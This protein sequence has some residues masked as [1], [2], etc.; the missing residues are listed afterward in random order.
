MDAWSRARVVSV[1]AHGQHTPWDED[2]PLTGINL[3]L[4]PGEVLTPDHV[5]EW[6][7][8]MERVE[9]WVCQS[10]IDLPLDP[11]LPVHN[12]GAGFDYSLLAAG[13][14]TTIATLWSVEQLASAFICLQFRL[15]CTTGDDAAVA[16]AAAQR[17]WRDEA[18]T[19]LRARLD[20]G[21]S[22]GEA[23]VGLWAALLG[24]S[25]PE[26]AASVI[27]AHL[28]ARGA[29]AL[30][31]HTLDPPLAHAAFRF[32]GVPDRAVEAVWD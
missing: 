20:A 21:A 22:A 7:Q 6:S 25:P 29:A 3:L 26:P 5:V 28:D 1:L 15:R 23:V 17:W 30:V 18:R 24:R 12:E 27:R 8:G 32:S 2:E 19:D 4:G 13:A 14:R 11:L 31:E 9:F 16:L 10:G